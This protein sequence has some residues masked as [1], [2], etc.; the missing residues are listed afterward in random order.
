M[1]RCNLLESLMQD[2]VP[3][4]ARAA[5]VIVYAYKL[6]TWPIQAHPLIG[7]PQGYAGRIR[8][9]EPIAELDIVDLDLDHERC[10]KSVFGQY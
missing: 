1:L 7:P 5:N 9:K 3:R 2:K 4:L 6:Q 10:P 8:A